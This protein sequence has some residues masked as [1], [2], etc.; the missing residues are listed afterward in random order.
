MVHLAFKYVAV[1][2]SS[3]LIIAVA[4]AENRAEKRAARQDK[5]IQQGEENLAID[6]MRDR[7]NR[8]NHRAQHSPKPVQKSAL[9]K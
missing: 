6:K 8:N 1:V 7:M 4:Q 2:A 3:L 5:R 9:K